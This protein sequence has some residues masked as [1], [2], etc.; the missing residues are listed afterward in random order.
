MSH[1]FL[2]SIPAALAVATLLLASPAGAHG[3]KWRRT[4]HGP[5][6]VY[7]GV[8]RYYAPP[9][10]VQPAYPVY[11]HGYRAEP[12]FCGPCSHHFSSYDDLSYHVHHRHGVAVLALPSVIIH[13][14]RVGWYFDY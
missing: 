2:R 10:V 9:V 13:A 12:F 6:V 7:Y 1:R 8:P 5:N 4:H 14:A 11:Y 3:P